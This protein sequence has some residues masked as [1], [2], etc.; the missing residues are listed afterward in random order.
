MKPL[1]RYTAIMALLC[2]GFLVQLSQYY[3]ARQ[4]EARVTAAALDAAIAD[5]HD[6][7]L[8][9]PRRIALRAHV[10]V[11]LDEFKDSL[12]HDPALLADLIIAKSE[13]NR[14]DPYLVLGVIKTE[15]DFNRFAVS[16]KGA[17]GLMQLRPHTASFLQGGDAESAGEASLY[18]NELNISLG[19]QYLA[20][21]IRRF[22]S[23]ELALEAYNRGPTQLRRQLND[24]DE[25]GRF[26]ARKVLDNYHLLRSATRAL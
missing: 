19:T 22:G 9:H 15:S 25:V 8:K 5:Q 23:L 16:P 20:R 4:Q 24:G 26:Y 3:K 18:D 6:W 1:H 2:T 21:L 14:L 17:V 13:E 10:A 7:N 11:I 12:H